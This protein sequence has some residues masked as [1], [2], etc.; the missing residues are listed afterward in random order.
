MGDLHTLPDVRQAER[1]AS[2]WIARLQADDVSA[3]DRARFEAWRSAH[4]CRAEAYE[5]LMGTWRQFAAAGPLVRAVSFAQSVSAP[6][7]VHM[8]RRRWVLTAVAAS[9]VAALLVVTAVHVARKPSGEQFT[10]AIGEQVTI[11][12]ADGS[13]VQLNSNSTAR[14]EYSAHARVIHLDKGEAFFEVA[15]DVS[16]PFWVASGKSWVRAVGT[17]FNV[18]VRRDGVQVIVS[19]G[20]V[21][22]GYAEPGRGT[23]SPDNPLGGVAVSVLTAGQEVEMLGS[24]TSARGLSAQELAR[25]VSWRDG[26]VYFENQTLGEVVEEVGRYTPL[27]LVVDDEKLR[28]LIVGGTFQANPQ[29]AEALLTMLEQ[30]FGLSVRREGDRAYIESGAE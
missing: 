27:R 30:G 23:T 9:T 20:V 29:G 10:T 14:V 26:T 19:E 2:E 5:K 15:H 11:S 12:L 18:N 7:D 1:E 3:D 24:K 4:S 16:R 8:P 25:A 21:K 13:T 6:I 28:D 17:A 22:V